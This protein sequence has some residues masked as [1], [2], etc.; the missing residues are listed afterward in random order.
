MKTKKIILTSLFLSTI[1]LTGCVTTQG[2]QYSNIQQ[3]Q[4]MGGTVLSIKEYSVQKENSNNLAIAGGAIVGGLLGN[5]VGKGTGKTLATVAGAGAGAY[6]ANQY[7]K[8]P[9]Q[10]PMV[11]ISVRGDNGRTMTINQEKN[12]NYRNGQRVNI[13]ITGNNAQINP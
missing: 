13:T 10:V 4:Q 11:E 12:Y 8:Q 7:T 9:T 2:P 3:S 5:Q 1:F 6:A